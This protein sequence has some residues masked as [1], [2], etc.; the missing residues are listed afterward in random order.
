[1]LL[2]PP[3]S[4]GGD[5]LVLRLAGASLGCAVVVAVTTRVTDLGQ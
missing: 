5:D 2:F 4:L 1:M 3:Q